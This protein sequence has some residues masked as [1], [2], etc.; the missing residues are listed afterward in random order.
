MKV[1]HPYIQ[2]NL[3]CTN[4]GYKPRNMHK[5]GPGVRD[6]YSLHYVISGKGY[7]ES[8]N[9]TYSVNAKE[10]FVIFPDIKVNYYPD[11]SDPWEY[12]WIDF[13]G[14]EALHILLMTDFREN[15]PVAPAFIENPEP[16]F[17]IAEITSKEPFAIERSNA[18]LRL[19]LSYYMEY[20]PKTNTIMKTDYVLLAKE[21]IENNYWKANLTVSDIVDFVRVERTHLYRLFKEATGMSLLTYL[22]A[23]RIHRACILLQTSE[24]SIKSVACS[25]GY[26][27]QLHF[28]K[29]FKKGTS[30]SPSEYKKEHTSTIKK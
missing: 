13:K 30:Y 16:F 29:I 24:L 11:S 3:I 23:Y 22:T 9:V 7:F 21:Y 18:K 10:S 27:D 4:S 12:I 14:E 15:N 19:L 26:L 20:H 25:V 6:I 5:W 2:K 28:S 1:I 8:N 17:H